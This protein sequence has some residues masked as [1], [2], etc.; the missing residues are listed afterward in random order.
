MTGTLDGKR[1]IVTGAGQGIGRGIALALAREGARVALA[2]RTESKLVAV[3]KEIGEIGGSA[4]TITADVTRPDDISR[5][6]GETVAALGGI[7]ILVNN[8]QIP[9]LGSM[10]GISEEAFTDC[11]ESGPLAVF[12]LM[13]ACHPHLADGGGVIINLGSPASINPQ[14]TGRGVYAAAKSAT[15]TLT[16]VAASEWGP[17][18]IR[19]LAVLPA[20]SSPA[21]EAWRAASPQE[22]ERSMASIPLRR[23]GDSETE[24]GPVV[25]F[26]CG[27][28][29]S[30]LTG[31]MIAL[32]GGQAYLR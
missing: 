20:A 7:D 16:R 6:V 24:I 5:I 21:S 9:A 26:L 8:A 22:Y 3:A 4:M 25:A 10:L 29:A 19:V 1:A 12:R 2:G 30:Y 31:T 15:Q 11:W 23:L 28:S 18:G 14:P 17:D 27:P 32:D 13:R